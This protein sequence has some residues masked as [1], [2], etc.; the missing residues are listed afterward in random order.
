MKREMASLYI[1]GKLVETYSMKLPKVT[2]PLGFCCLGTNPPAA[3]AGM[4]DK[5]R[6]C[7]LYAELGPV[8]IFKDG[9][10]T[11]AFKKLYERW[12]LRAVLRVGQHQESLLTTA[13]SSSEP[14]SRTATGNVAYL[15]LLQ[16][17]SLKKTKKRYSTSCYRR[18]FCNC[19]ILP[20][21]KSRLN[22]SQT[23]HLLFQ[24]MEKGK[25][26]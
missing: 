9:L 12:E 5:R 13:L 2:K 19:S 7:A 1:N 25:E 26:F 24:A 23:L 10:G 17:L 6:Q 20:Y 22:L 16:L 3:M 8:Y 4:Q 18:N 21:Q 11:Q 14:L 15:V